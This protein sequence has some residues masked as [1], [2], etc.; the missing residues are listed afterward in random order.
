MLQ[1]HEFF[2]KIIGE[3]SDLFG[4]EEVEEI[5]AGVKNE[6]RASGMFDSKENCWN[7]F[8]ERVRNQLKVCCCLHFTHESFA[9]Q[10]QIAFD[11]ELESLVRFVSSSC[12]SNG[13]F[14]RGDVKLRFANNPLSTEHT[15]ALSSKTY[16]G[17][18]VFQVFLD[19]TLCQ[20][21]PNCGTRTASG[22]RR[23][24]R[25]YVNRPTFY[26]SSKTYIYSYSFP[27]WVL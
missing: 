24:S 13:N 7:F 16:L 12:Y 2:C 5:I 18:G 23:P 15:C 10:F 1:S 21:F 25:W 6:V 11:C 9:C 22:T 14:L 20:W 3:I 27:Y 19:D 4:D 26:F 8:L 17:V